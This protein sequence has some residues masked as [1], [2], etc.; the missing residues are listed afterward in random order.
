MKE[1]NTHLILLLSFSTYA[2]DFA[3]MVD[4]LSIAKGIE[5]IATTGF[6]VA[7]E[8][9]QIANGIG[10]AGVE[11][12]IYSKD[13]SSFS[14][15]LLLI[16]EKA[17][18]PNGV[19]SDELDL[20]KLVTDICEEVWAP[21][22]RIQETLKPLLEK[23]KNSNRKFEQIKKRVQWYF[24]Q[25]QNLLFYREALRNHQ[26]NLE[27]ALAAMNYSATRDM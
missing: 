15:V 7:Q 11:V 19:T 25:K 10:S 16:K 2:V 18:R 6:T 14:K 4:P 8:L 17:L 13:I 21:L 27:I 23:Y 26:H 1:E 12:R 20:L 22:K 3:T 5:I 9:Y 24:S